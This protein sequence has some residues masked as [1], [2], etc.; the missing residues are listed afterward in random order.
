VSVSSLS[1]GAYTATLKVMV[2]RVKGGGGVHP[3]PSLARADFYDGMYAR[4]R[5]L[6]FCV[7]SVGEAKESQ[8][9]LLF[10][11]VAGP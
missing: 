5:H 8:E 9:V 1:A 6:P 3:P 11:D 10:K 7:Y 2:T 4:N